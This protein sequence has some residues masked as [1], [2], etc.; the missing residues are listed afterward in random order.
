[1]GRPIKDRTGQKIGR[2]TVIELVDRKPNEDVKWLCKCDC[3]KYVTVSGGNLGRGIV[4]CGCRKKE[5]LNK[6]KFR[7]T[8]GKS[9]TR[10]YGVWGSMVDRC[11]NPNANEYERYGGRGIKV[12]DEWRNDYETFE[13]WA[14]ENGYDEKSDR[15]HSTLDRIDVNGNYEPGNCRFTS[16]KMQNRNRSSNVMITY[17]GETHCISEW[18][19]IAGLQYGT[20]LKRLK[21]GWSMEQAMNRPL[22]YTR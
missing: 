6:N 5:V 12:C 16:M 14:L 21:A 3:G 13:A 20:F 15:A 17:R 9:R 4:S 18:A 10:L 22:I 1:M 8:H 11:T 2:L 19:E 7:P